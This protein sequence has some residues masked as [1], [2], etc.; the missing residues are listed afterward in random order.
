MTEHLVHL[1]QL[2]EERKLK[3][4]EEL[5]YKLSMDPEVV[6]KREAE[7]AEKLKLEEEERKKKAEEER[8]ARLGKIKLIFFKLL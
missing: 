4:L 1:I 6:A 7:A 3:K 2:N 8:Q 5:T